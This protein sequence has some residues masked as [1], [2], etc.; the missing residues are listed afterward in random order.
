MATGRHAFLACGAVRCCFFIHR[1]LDLACQAL[2]IVYCVASYSQ[3]PALIN[4]WRQNMLMNIQKRCSISVSSMANSTH[5]IV[6]LFSSVVNRFFLLLISTKHSVFIQVH[7]QGTKPTKDYISFTLKVFIHLWFSLSDV[8]GVNLCSPLFS[9]AVIFRHIQIFMLMSVLWVYS[10]HRTV[11]HRGHLL[12]IYQL[13]LVLS[14][15]Q[16]QVQSP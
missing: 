1:L 2:K 10:L 16:V 15:I 8:S 13:L 7:F 4:S 3:W 6:V 11:Q 5:P 9:I 12:I 14:N